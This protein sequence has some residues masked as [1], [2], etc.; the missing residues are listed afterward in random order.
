MFTRRHRLQS[1]I[2]TGFVTFPEMPDGRDFPTVITHITC[3]GYLRTPSLFL[4]YHH[5]LTCS[6]SVS[7]D[8]LCKSL[9]NISKYYK[10][11]RKI[12]L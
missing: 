11:N 12:S 3:H 9:C 1:H 6:S 8:H 2:V 4:S 10:C 5:H 7:F